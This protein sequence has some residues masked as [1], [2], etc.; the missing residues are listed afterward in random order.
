MSESN[1]S[2]LIASDHAG[3][4]LKQKIIAKMG[5][6][7][8]KDLGTQDA[9]SV[10]YPDYADRV[11]ALINTEPSR[12]GILICGSGQGM[13]MRANKYPNVRAAL[14]GSKE[15]AQLAREH[16][17]ANILCLGARFLDEAEAQEI[18]EVFLKTAF[19]GGRHQQRVDK[20]K[21]TLK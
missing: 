12:R 13:A 15:L 4:D 11:A 9:S 20:L 3:F 18:I 17:D 7:T 14:V 5:N 16:N 2:L 6:L 8:W 10:D 1:P 21:L 19:A